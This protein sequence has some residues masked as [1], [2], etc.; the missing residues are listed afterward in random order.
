MEV[1]AAAEEVEAVVVELVA[2]GLVVLSVASMYPR[3]R[4]N[5]LGKS[6]KLRKKNFQSTIKQTVRC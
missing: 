3:E 2:T 5:Q 1:T 6:E 4:S